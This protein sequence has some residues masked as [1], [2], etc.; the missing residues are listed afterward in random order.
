MKKFQ[1]IR[2]RYLLG[3]CSLIK[4]LLIS[5]QL[6]FLLE[7]TNKNK[8]FRSNKGTQGRNCIAHT[9]K[10][11]NRGIGIR[12][13]IS[14]MV[15]YRPVSDRISV[16]ISIGPLKNRYVSAKTWRIGKYLNSCTPLPDT[17]LFGC[18]EYAVMKLSLFI[19]TYVMSEHVNSNSNSSSSIRLSPNFS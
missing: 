5:D 12:N 7:E 13:G 14:D 15:R 3:N 18:V 9:T 16:N 11:L 17:H 4:L 6:K 10:V 1:L 8:R 2:Y 19:R